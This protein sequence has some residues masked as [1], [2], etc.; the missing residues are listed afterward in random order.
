MPTSLDLDFVLIP[1]GD[2]VMGSNLAAYRAAGADE[3]PDHTLSISD[4][5]IMRYPVTNAQYRLFREA[6]GHRA[7]LT[8]RDGIFPE[9]RACRTTMRWR[10]AA[11]RAR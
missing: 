2:F 5:Y 1:A 6:T 4:Y 7:P 8:W 3:V 11:G 10:S 9:E